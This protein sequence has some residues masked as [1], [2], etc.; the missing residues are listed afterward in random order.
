MWRAGEKEET[1][2]SWKSGTGN[3][4]GR[5]KNQRQGEDLGGENEDNAQKAEKWTAWYNSVQVS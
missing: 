2:N 3:H 5:G 1:G 4:Q